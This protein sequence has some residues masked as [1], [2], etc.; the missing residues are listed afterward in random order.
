MRE[1]ACKWEFFFSE[2]KN[3]EIEKKKKIVNEN[4]REYLPSSSTHF[5]VLCNSLST[6]N[7]IMHIITSHNNYKLKIRQCKEFTRG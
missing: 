1:S 7:T 2:Q 4:V 5:T 3:N 6:T